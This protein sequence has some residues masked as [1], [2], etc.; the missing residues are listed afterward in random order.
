MITMLYREHFR[1]N[2][3]RGVCEWILS[4]A[5]WLLSS[6]QLQNFVGIESIKYWLELDIDH[7]CCVLGELQYE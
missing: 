1:S 5:G 6:G 3:D 4:L 7:L 2:P